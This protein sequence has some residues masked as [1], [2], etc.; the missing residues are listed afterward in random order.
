[1][2]RPVRRLRAAPRR[3]RRR[4][5]P[6]RWRRAAWSVVG[7]VLCLGGL[8]A[9][10]LWSLHG[11]PL[12]A[13]GSLQKPF[14]GK[15]QV[16]ILVLGLDDGQGGKGRSDTMLLVHVDAEARRLAALSIPRDTR[17][18]I[19]ENRFSKINAAHARGGPLAA[20]QAV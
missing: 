9:G 16:N 17:V 19:G 18:P 20:A 15:R 11:G 13:I 10:A 5:A 7:F 4:R 3:P 1:M 12:A 8:T 14:G 2:P 6:A